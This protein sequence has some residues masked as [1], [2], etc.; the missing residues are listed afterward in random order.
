VDIEGTDYPW[1]A[2]TITTAQLRQL[3][4]WE[5]NQQVVAVDLEPM[6]ETTLADDDVVTLMS[7]RGVAKKIRFKR[8]LSTGVASADALAHGDA[9][10]TRSL[11]GWLDDEDALSHLLGRGPTP[12][13]DLMEPTKKIV[14]AKA[15]VSERP[16]FEVGDPTVPGDSSTL[17]QIAAR[18]DVQSSFA[19][20]NWS[21]QWVD[22]NRVQS[23]QK[24]I[25]A[26]HLAS[27]VAVAAQG[28]DALADLCFPRSQQEQIQF[29][30]DLDG[31]GASISTYNPHLRVGCLPPQQMLVASAPGNL[32]QQVLSLPFGI[33]LGISYLHV[34]QYQDR[35]ILRDGTHRAAGLLREGISV[36]P[37]VIVE[38]PSWEFVAPIPGL[39]PEATVLGDRPP[40]LTDFWHEVASA[41]GRQQRIKTCWYIRANRIPVPV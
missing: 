23:V 9:R 10:P 11:I 15:A 35:F 13:D 24:F 6:T 21:V 4:I 31:L 34:A 7:R 25:Y 1:D 38:A 29:N 36:V 39:L 22:L 41:D 27:R 16:K 33:N 2:P 5:P 8:G 30:V 17:S 19:G 32:P 3:A 18:P 26:D 40:L 12:Q 37:A 20:A 28:S 14:A